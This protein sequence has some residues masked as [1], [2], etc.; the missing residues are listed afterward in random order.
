MHGILNS[1]YGKRRN[2]Q[3]VKGI[4]ELKDANREVCGIVR[5][6]FDMKCLRIQKGVI[7][8]TS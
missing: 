4:K 7:E 1:N 2:K 5:D 3:N 6:S 8:W